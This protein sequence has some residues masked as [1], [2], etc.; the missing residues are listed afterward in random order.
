MLNNTPPIGAAN[1]AATPAATEAPRIWLL[2]VKFYIIFTLGRF[3]MYFIFVILLA[4]IADICTN[5]PS[6]PILSP[7]A[8]PAIS[9]TIFAERVEK[10]RYLLMWIPDSID[11]T[12][13]IPEPSAS[14]LMN[15]PAEAA[16]QAKNKE[17]NIH[18]IKF[19]ITLSEDDK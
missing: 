19:P 10:L 1:A 12:S 16:M 4:S 11:F 14:L 18:I 17:Y 8:D 5:G 9:P 7:A 3:L 6:L 13:G 2:T 15:F